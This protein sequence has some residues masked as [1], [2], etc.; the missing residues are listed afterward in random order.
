MLL[1]SNLLLW[2][3]SLTQTLIPNQSLRCGFE[4]KRLHL[5]RILVELT[6]RSWFDGQ[7]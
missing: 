2:S 1:S 4:V 3:S 5:S 7:L 6:V